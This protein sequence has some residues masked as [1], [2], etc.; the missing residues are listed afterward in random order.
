MRCPLLLF[1]VQQD[2]PPGTARLGGRQAWTFLTSAMKSW[3]WDPSDSDVFH[4]QLSDSGSLRSWCELSLYCP[5]IMH[6]PSRWT[7]SHREQ[8]G[9]PALLLVS[10]WSWLLGVRMGARRR[11]LRVGAV[12]ALLAGV[13]SHSPGTL[14]KLLQPTGPGCLI[15]H[16]RRG[17]I[18]AHGQREHHGS[19]SGGVSA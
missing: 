3:P 7:W 4:G 14:N 13:S 15:L 17:Y 11:E 1:L 6:S 2:S 9:L 8:W 10:S 19:I 5:P 12:L 18:T 16:L